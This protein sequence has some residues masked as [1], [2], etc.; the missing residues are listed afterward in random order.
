MIGAVLTALFFGVTP[1]C[2]NRAIKLIGFVRANVLRLS[3]AVVVMAIWA[4]SFGQGLGGESLLFAGA[5]VIGFGVGGL[6][7]LAALPRLGAPLAS[8]IEESA[9]APVAAVVAWVWYADRLTPGQIGF[10]AIIL[11]GVVVGLLPYLRGAASKGARLGIALAL[12]AALA[13]GVS[14]AMTR[15]G[16]L[17]MKAAHTPPDTITV[18]FQR[19]VGGFVVAV[20]V[21][22]VA[23]WIWR[24]RW[25]FTGGDG[26]IRSILA[27][28]GSITA[29]PLFWAG[30]NS[31]FGPIL[32]VTCTV[33]AQQ[34]L[35]PGVVQAI[36]AM[37][38]LISVPFARWLEGHRPPRLY[39]LGAVI[40][41]AGLVLVNVVG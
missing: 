25:G 34:S 15:R 37:A 10:S 33:W 14:F 28:D 39:Y 11:V 1:V 2:A 13:Q 5:G 31:L 23:R 22:L 19:L 17:L 27:S 41:I 4:F 29:R 35:Q 7:L 20:V 24:R 26:R 6:S 21:F 40:A 9:A 30:L 32:G 16:L 12:L 38:P 18:A 8:L 3:F 36:A